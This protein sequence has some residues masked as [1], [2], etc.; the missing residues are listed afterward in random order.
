MIDTPQ[1]ERAG[2]PS[3]SGAHR[4]LPCPGSFEAEQGLPD[5]AGDDA[6]EGQMLHAVMAGEKTR[7]AVTLDEGQIYAL[8]FCEEQKRRI[9]SQ[10]FGDTPPTDIRVEQRLWLR[11][12]SL[13]PVASARFDFLA[14]SAQAGFVPDWKFGRMPVEAADANDQLRF[15][16]AAFRQEC[17]D[18]SEFFAAIIAPRADGERVTLARYSA[19]QMDAAVREMVAGAKR[20][21]RP[22]QPRVP[23]PK[24]CHF[25]RAKGTDRCPESIAS[26]TALSVVPGTAITAAQ[27]GD[28]LDRC[29]LADTVVEAIR[30]EAVRQLNAG[31]EIP[32]WRLEE[33]NET[34]T[35][36]DPLK[37]WAAVGV[38]I[39]GAAFAQ[40][41][42]FSRTKLVD[43]YRRQFKCASEKQARDEVTKLLDEGDALTRKQNRPSL[44]R[45][46]AK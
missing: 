3:G 32:G 44:K 4:W 42:K 38:L 29:E 30:A 1:T 35:I 45:I 36:N 39:G 14:V 34:A 15:T 19:R 31:V 18:V 8:D 9:M 26:A 7:E 6:T 46:S 11:D 5:R 24:A 25:C 20:A 10:V 28:L 37:A 2:K 43:A 13:E 17:P 33:G 21:M 23:S 12:D 27:L 41:G 22:N 16:A 40:C